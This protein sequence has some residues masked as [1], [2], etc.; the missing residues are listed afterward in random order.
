MQKDLPP[1]IRILGVNLI[2]A[3]AGNADTCAG[4]VLPWLQDTPA[5]QAWTAWDVA[6]RDVVILDAEGR[7]VAVHNLTENNLAVRAR[8][9]ELRDLLL[10]H[11]P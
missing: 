11:A 5:A 4:R 1:G 9:E 10:A 2:G 8:Y 7:P 3:E 6:Y